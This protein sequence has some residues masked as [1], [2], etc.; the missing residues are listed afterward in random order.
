VF[1]SLAV[2][3]VHLDGSA[4]V[5]LRG[6]IDI[7]SESV[8]STAVERVMSLGIPVV[9]DF[10]GVTFMDSSGLKVLLVAQTADPSG[11]LG[12]RNPSP[13]VRRLL[14]VTG[15]DRV[16]SA[17]TSTDAGGSHFDATLDDNNNR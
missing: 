12:V 11:F 17:D 8:F 7:A 16:I 9:L 10:A 5:M 1:E 4:V 13:Q 15:L 14:A 3:L 6:E 2:D